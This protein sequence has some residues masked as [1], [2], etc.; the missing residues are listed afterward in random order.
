VAIHTDWHFARPAH[1]RLSLELSWHWLLA[2]P[3]FAFAAAYVAR[4]WAKQPWRSSVAI[5]GTAVVIAGILE[6]LWEYV[7]GGAS[8][9]WAFGA[10][11]NIALLSFIGTGVVV[12]AVTLAWLRR[13]THFADAG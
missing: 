5:I 2:I 11:R 1:H 8:F 7:I 10:Q 12:Y 3:V 13:K 4:T 6:P 9:D